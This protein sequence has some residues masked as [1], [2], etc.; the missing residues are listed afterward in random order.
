MRPAVHVRREHEVVEDELAPPLEE[1]EQARPSTGPLELVVL[2][3]AEDRLPPA[4]GG[5]RVARAGRGLFL[6]EQALV[7]GLPRGG[8][9]D[10]R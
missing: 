5:Q 6:G 8:R 9:D 3:D 2:L 10:V 1:V 4:L 7:R